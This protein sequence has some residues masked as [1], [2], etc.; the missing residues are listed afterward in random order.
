MDNQLADT[1]KEVL[2]KW[3]AL[4]GLAVL[5][6]VLFMFLGFRQFHAYDPYTK[7]V[8]SI[9]GDPV[10]GHAIFQMNCAGCH[11]WVLESQIG[12]YLEGISQRKS[13]VAII[14]QVV[15]GQTPPM[16]QFQPSDR[17]MADLLSYL[18]QM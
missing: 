4:V 18:K 2:L 8:L 9:D 6:V 3:S 15:S 13:D 11:E 5:L 12:P 10:Q 17:E 14:K 7:R 16:P 1:K